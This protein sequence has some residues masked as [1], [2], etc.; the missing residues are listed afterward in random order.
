MDKAK[1]V[2]KKIDDLEKETETNDN[3]LKQEE[4]RSK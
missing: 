3:R 4:P 1:K 2:E